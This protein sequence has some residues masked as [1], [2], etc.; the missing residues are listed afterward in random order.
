MLTS[1]HVHVLLTLQLCSGGTD[2]VTPEQGGDSAWG[3]GL[4]LRLHHWA[5]AK[6]LPLVSGSDQKEHLSFYSGPYKTLDKL[7]NSY[8]P[9]FSQIQSRDA[10]IFTLCCSYKV[11]SQ[12]GHIGSKAISPAAAG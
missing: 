2:S 10:V 6:I 3:V 4:P 5:A 12:H 7:F 8:L 9:C 11:L 1:V